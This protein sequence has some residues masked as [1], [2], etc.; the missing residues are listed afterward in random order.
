MLHVDYFK[1]SITEKGRSPVTEEFTQRDTEISEGLVILSSVE[2]SDE[3]NPSRV[4]KR[5]TREIAKHA[6]ALKVERI[7]LHPFAHLFAEL[8]SPQTAI[9]VLRLIE[10]GLYREGFRTLR[11]PFGWFNTLEIK[12]KGHPLSR[13]A[14]RVESLGGTRTVS[15]EST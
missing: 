2:R 11:T 9:E 5:A 15:A 10:E 14:R 6:R 3:D 8:A 12:A 7:V 13:V 4:A 1:C